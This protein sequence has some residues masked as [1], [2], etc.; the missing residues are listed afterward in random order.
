L[1]SKKYAASGP[2]KGLRVGIASSSLFA[3]LLPESDPVIFW[4]S[5]KYA[6]SGLAKGL[7]VGIASVGRFDSYLNRWQD[8]SGGLAEA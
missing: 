5:K 2:A 7:R 4:L 8:F 1:L 3:R 6:A